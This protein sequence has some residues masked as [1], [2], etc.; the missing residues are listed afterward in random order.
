MKKS[1][2]K[3]GLKKQVDLIICMLVWEGGEALLLHIEECEQNL[4]RAGYAPEISVSQKKLRCR[5]NRGKKEG[6]VYTK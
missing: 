6:D 2:L 3:L 1:G 5:M 4:K